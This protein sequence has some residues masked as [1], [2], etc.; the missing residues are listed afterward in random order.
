M[1]S[2]VMC[3]CGTVMYLNMHKS[4][5][6]WCAPKVWYCP[7]CGMESWEWYRG[8]VVLVPRGRFVSDVFGA[9]VFRDEEAG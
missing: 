7:A 4:G 5:D 3:L 2:E 1:R 8:K 6:E 9:L